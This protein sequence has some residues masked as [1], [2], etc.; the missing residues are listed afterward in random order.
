MLLISQDLGVVNFWRS[1][2]LAVTGIYAPTLMRG[3]NRV[4]ILTAATIVFGG[5]TLGTALTTSYH[6]YFVLR[7]VNGIGVCV[8][9]VG[10]YWQIGRLSGV[11]SVLYCVNMIGVYQVCLDLLANW[12]AMRHSE[13]S[14]HQPVLTSMYNIRIDTHP[15]Y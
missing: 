15:Y 10:I 5:S 12:L 11:Y 6:V 1:M 4:H 3:R 14:T 7:C 13:F 2:A 8:G 9:F